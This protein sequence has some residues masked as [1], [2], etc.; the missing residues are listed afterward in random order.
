MEKKGVSQIVTTILI[1]LLVLAAIVIVWQAVKGT[2][3][4][5]AET[6]ESKTQCM[7][8]SLSIVS[9][10]VSD[11][12]VKVMRLSGGNNDVVKDVKILVEGISV[13]H[14]LADPSLDV[15]ESKSYTGVT[16]VA[17]N[18]VQVAAVLTDGTVCDISDTATA[19]D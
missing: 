8:I 17:E 11:S 1:I 2:I 10:D 19:E 13:T 14:N 3:E 16:M 12:T 5:G 6:I 18:E 9:A 15:L 4:K 7:D